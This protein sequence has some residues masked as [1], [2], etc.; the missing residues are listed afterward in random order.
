MDV[1]GIFNAGGVVIKN[2]NY[3]KS[4][5]NPQPEYITVSDLDRAIDTTGS[6]MADIAYDA[7][8][9]YQDII[10][11][12][13]DL[14]KYHEYGINPTKYDTPESLQRQLAKNQSN[15]AKVFNAV[16]QTLVNEFILGIGAAA[17]DIVDY[18]IGGLIRKISG[19]NNDYSNPIGDYLR[20]KQ[21]EFKEF[22]PVYVDPEGTTLVDQFKGNLNLGYWMSNL[23]NIATTVTLML[24]GKAVA[25]GAGALTKAIRLNKAVRAAS[26]AKKTLEAGK[27]LNW[28]QKAMISRSNRKA[29]NT[30]GKN[31][32][33]AA[34][35]RLAENY[36]EAIQ[37]NQESYK[38]NIDYLNS[39]SDKEYTE[40]LQANPQI[41]DLTDEEGNPINVLDKNQV[42]KAVAK[43]AADETFKWDM[44]NTVFDV[45]QVYSLKNAGNLFKRTFKNSAKV[46]AA[47]KSIRS[48]LN[49]T[50]DEIAKEEAAK[51]WYT[52][53]GERLTNIGTGTALTVGSELSEGVEEAVNYVAQQEGLNYGKVLLGTESQSSFDDRFTQY[54]KAPEL[55]DSAF[56]GVLGGVAFNTIGSAFNA[57][58]GKIKDARKKEEDATTKESLTNFIFGTNNE[59]QDR[60][61]SLQERNQRTQRFVE[62]VTQLKGNVDSST[63]EFEGGIN[64]DTGTALSKEEAE[65]LI[66]QEEDDYLTDVYMNAARNGNLGLLREFL[67]SDDVIT[68]FKNNGVGVTQEEVDARVA[69]LDRI[70]K[71]FE[72]N[73]SRVDIASNNIGK[74]SKMF[75]YDVPNDEHKKVLEKIFDMDNVPMEY[76]LAIADR[77]TRAQLKI[78]EYQDLL[79][80]QQAIADE[81]IENLKANGKLDSTM[82]YDSIVKL[83]VLSSQLGYVKQERENIEKDPAKFKTLSGQIALDN[84]KQQERI[85]E[86]MI[87]NNAR[88]NE[89]TL[90]NLIFA[91][92][93]ASSYVTLSDGSRGVV[94]NNRRGVSPILDSFLDEV[95]AVQ[96]ADGTYS[97]FEKL[98]DY[99]LKHN[100]ILPE[101]F[102]S[103]NVANRVN[104]LAKN[105]ENVFKEASD[106]IAKIAPQAVDSLVSA[107]LLEHLIAQE[108]ASINLTP[109][110]VAKEVGKMNNEMYEARVNA[111]NGSID[112]LISLFDK[113]AV[114]GEESV[115]VLDSILYDNND[116]NIVSRMDEKDKDSWNTA[117]TVLNLGSRNNNVLKRQVRDILTRKGYV[118]AMMQAGAANTPT[119]QPVTTPANNNTSSTTNTNTNTTT[120]NN[121]TPSTTISEP[122]TTSSNNISPTQPQSNVGQTNGQNQSVSPANRT[123]TKLIVNSDNTI[124]EDDKGI[125]VGVV[126]DEDGSSEIIIPNDGTHASLL[127]NSQLFDIEQSV[128]DGG[129]VVK[130][131]IITTDDDGNVQVLRKGIITN[132]N[133]YTPEEK[134]IE[135]ETPATEPSI[136]EGSPVAISSSTGVLEGETPSSAEGVYDT[137]RSDAIIDVRTSLFKAINT[138]E[139]LDALAKNITTNL[140]ND[141]FT[142][143]EATSLVNDTLNR[144]KAMKKLLNGS[145]S[146][147]VSAI[148]KL[149]EHSSLFMDNPTSES[150]ITNYEKAFFDVIKAYASDMKLNKIN[151]RYYIVTQDL[152]R[153]CNDI[154]EDKTIAEILYD[155]IVKYFEQ[156]STD[157]INYVIIDKDALISNGF[158]KKVA[159]SIDLNLRKESQTKDH[160]VDIISVIRDLSKEDRE[161]IYKELEKLK[162]GS[163][164]YYTI[165][166]NEDA[167]YVL[168]QA[169]QRKNNR[170]TIGKLPLPSRVD[171]RYNWINMGWSVDVGIDSSNK[172]QSNLKEFLV[173]LF[174]PQTGNSDYE[175]FNNLLVE[176]T[177]SKLSDNRKKEILNELRKFYERDEFKQYIDVELDDKTVEQLTNYLR[178]L[179]S[180]MIAATNTSI[181]N[182]DRRR[183]VETSLNTWFNKLYDSYDFANS[184]ALKENGRIT[185]TQIHRGTPIFTTG[186]VK[187]PATKALTPENRKAAKIGVGTYG[188]TIVLSDG[189][190]TGISSQS[191]ITY[192]VIPNGTDRVK[193][194]VWPTSFNKANPSPKIEL[195]KKAIEKEM[196][197]A[198]DAYAKDYDYDRLYKFIDGLFGIGTNS[199]G[200]CISAKENN[201]YKVYAQ[202]LANNL[203]IKIYYNGKSLT[204]Y[205]G[206]KSGTSNSNKVYFQGAVRAVN[207]SGTQTNKK[208]KEA[209]REMF[210]SLNFNINFKYASNTQFTVGFV[211]KD[212]KG[213][214]NIKIGDSTPIK[215]N[216]LEDFFINNDLVDLSIE[217]NK[218][219]TSNFYRIGEDIEDSIETNKSRQFLRIALDSKPNIVE[220]SSP[221]EKIADTV[222]D[223][224]KA[225]IDDILNSEK[226]DVNEDGVAIVDEIAPELSDKLTDIVYKDDSISLLP[227]KMVLDI[228]LT[229]RAVFNKE[230]GITRISQALYDN[231]NSP[232]KAIRYAGVKTLVHEKIHDIIHRDGNEKYIKQ[233]REVY[234]EAKDAI[235]QMLK[236]NN[237]PNP[238]IT[239]ADGNITDAGLEEFITY[240]LTD[241]R[242]ANLLNSMDAEGNKVDTE[243]MSILQ[244]IM[245]IISDMFGWGIRDNSL[246]AKE[247]NALRDL[248]T[249]ENVEETTTNEEENSTTE[250]TET[251][252]L[253]LEENKE[254]LTSDISSDMELFSIFAD[255]NIN[256]N[257][258]L[259]INSVNIAT[260]SKQIPLSQRNK[261]IDNV[262]SGL[263]S[264]I[265]N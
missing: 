129:E 249:P 38:Y 96:N 56:W 228:F 140:M 112:T 179:Y 192:V 118:K 47:D 119:P 154:C 43:N 236:D 238:F 256:S 216:S 65:L 264:Q 175:Y 222:I 161:E 58:A 11:E 145:H 184:I 227:N 242:F 19:E 190:D 115:E 106:S 146:K 180:P 188:G 124:S 46:K 28:L 123:T 203:G 205:R 12:S 136:P 24:P 135:E 209:F 9:K 63:G 142:R 18:T 265:C 105:N 10:G 71:L 245:K 244:K 206:Y 111:I 81:E 226:T 54:L 158:L 6:A 138:D 73:V 219:G 90:A 207:A 35:M 36:Q 147:G 176:Y 195:I 122:Q 229:Q 108:K 94:N 51:T 144:A 248:M 1:D 262:K 259:K 240:S 239:D 23:P 143:D 171:G 200:I 7:A 31:V 48:Q 109:D 45:W 125:E 160:R 185:V 196:E 44:I 241:S 61:N 213:K 181:K 29:I 52:K 132:P 172:I 197:A 70:D 164:L 191:G 235:Q 114:E 117:M 246:Y 210:G 78:E 98:D 126:D 84:L 5:K 133:T 27:E 121:L 247:F 17:A 208:L 163:K 37:T 150:N 128:I 74:G 149:G 26:G 49:K 186:N 177:F 194:N 40:W 162:P 67:K 151:G 139:D 41:N 91:Q 113:Y 97:D 2:P 87:H 253:N 263:I 130:N 230:T 101:S 212:A 201:R 13:K 34:T 55:W 86:E 211:S 103:K 152:L 60:I 137:K 155:G 148:A 153:Y 187:H 199:N 64:P 237:L 231:L 173:N 80:E 193:I 53:A 258:K 174:T 183:I 168:I 243:N 57:M 62:R 21:E 69:K 178:N 220:T 218:E 32:T 8:P 223:A 225:K 68:F 66:R 198:I 215:F 232:S 260:A 25:A 82:D 167:G 233:I 104:Q 39:L 250:E 3:T 169:G 116:N 16:S 165:G 93:K 134:S 157:T 42:A 33:N 217:T 204:I 159:N 131:P 77:N 166:D 75:A 95:G 83:G 254:N 189:T 88:A 92:S 4:K 14:D 59:T 255:D 234:D 127:T 50:A 100:G 224:H 252:N 102:D 141:G 170:K 214:Y 202:P 107:T 182:S 20:Q 156:Q 221:V 99:I 257:G 22:A 15:F 30:I 72:E 261:F 251:S 85:I 89:D 79:G 110:E 120:Q 76:I